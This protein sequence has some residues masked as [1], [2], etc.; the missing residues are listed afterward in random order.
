VASRQEDDEDRE[1]RATKAS[2]VKRNKVKLFVEQS[3]A[4]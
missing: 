2:Q 4:E 3:V 1:G